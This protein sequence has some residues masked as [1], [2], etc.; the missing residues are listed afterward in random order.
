MNSDIP[1]IINDEDSNCYYNLHGSAY[2]KVSPSD[3]SGLP[4]PEIVFTGYPELHI[5]N[6]Q[7]IVQIE[8]GKP[9]FLTNI[10]TGY[11]KAQKGMISPFKQMH[12]TFDRDCCNANSIYLVGYSFGDEHINESLKIALRYNNNL[13]LEIVNP[14][15]FNDELDKKL[16]LNLFPY[17]EN[18][19]FNPKRISENI[20]S[21][22]SDRI[23]VYTLYFKDYLAH[24]KD[25]FL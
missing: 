6:E 23:V 16:V 3:F 4:N 13:K 2:W 14:N 21:Y 1:K 25:N 17:L 24:K 12:S 7:S 18:E 5:N 8:K 19:L 10:I 22:F 20:I 11:Q 15:F 9:L